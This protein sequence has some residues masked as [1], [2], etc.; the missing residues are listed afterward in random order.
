MKDIK[1]GEFVYGELVEVRDWDD[2]NWVERFYVTSIDGGDISQYYTMGI[3]Q[4]P[5]NFDGNA[6]L[7][8]QIRK[9]EF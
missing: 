1:E 4:D 3:D 8:R 9:I 5:N 6:I 2:Q 7:W